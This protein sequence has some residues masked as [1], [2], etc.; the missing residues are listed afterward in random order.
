MVYLKVLFLIY[1]NYILNA[2]VS[3][4]LNRLFADDD[5]AFIS[6]HSAQDL[7]DSITKIMKQLF[8]WFRANK[9]T[10]NLNKTCYTIFRSINKKRPR[11]SIQ[12][13][14]WW[15]HYKMIKSAKYV[16][17][18]LD[19]HLNWQEHIKDINISLT[20]MDNSFKIIKHQIPESSKLL[21]YN[22]Y[23]FSKIQYGIEVYGQVSTS[24]K[25]SANSTK[26][27]F[28]NTTQ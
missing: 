2:S 7:K 23:I 21:F 15:H 11:F 16:G 27:S 24:I 3:D 14:N 9:L 8:E 26:L 10:V 4:C 6:I 13:Q 1:I 18:T 5:N 17:L 28:K 20:K 22:D 12:H 25:K 19:E